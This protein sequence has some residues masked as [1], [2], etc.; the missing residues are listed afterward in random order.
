MKKIL[1]ILFLKQ[2]LIGLLIGTSA[3]LGGNFLM[4]NLPAPAP[5]LAPGYGYGLCTGG[6]LVYVF[7]KTAEIRR[8]VAELQRPPVRSPLDQG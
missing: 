4:A 1:L 7:L 2:S 5:E 6:L 3:I 8:V